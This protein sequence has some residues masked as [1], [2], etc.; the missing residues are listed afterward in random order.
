MPLC[1]VG[2]NHLIVQFLPVDADLP[3]CLINGFRTV[4]HS[5]T[6]VA[7][8][9]DS[10][11]LRAIPRPNERWIASPE[12]DSARKVFLQD[13]QNASR[14]PKISSLKSCQARERIPNA[15]R[16]SVEV[17]AAVLAFMP[18]VRTDCEVPFIQ[19]QGLAMWATH[20][21][22]IPLKEPR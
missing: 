9:M 20:Y 14:P 19:M 10:N 2:P 16:L 21:F 11:F 18:P 15:L 1:H 6:F 12:L 22:G 17:A 5:S 3:K 4:G 7:V 8:D 13:I